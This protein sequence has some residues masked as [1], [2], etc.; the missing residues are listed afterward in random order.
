MTSPVMRQE[1]AFETGHIHTNR[2]LRFAGAT[3]Q[4]KIERFVN[5]FAGEAIW[6]QFAGHRKPQNVGPAA[7]TVLL[8]ARRPECKG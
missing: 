8:I 1:L 7:R 2:A 3:L 4:A 6:A 5:P